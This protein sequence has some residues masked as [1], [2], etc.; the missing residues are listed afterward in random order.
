MI[1]RSYQPLVRFSDQ[2]F[3]SESPAPSSSAT[4][5][6]VY[7]LNTLMRALWEARFEMTSSISLPCSS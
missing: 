3:D 5:R 2:L 4:V 7:L 6:D 1:V